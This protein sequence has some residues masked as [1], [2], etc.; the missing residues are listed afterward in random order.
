[1]CVENVLSTPNFKTTHIGL[2]GP[3]KKM[4]VE[5]NISGHSFSWEY[6]FDTTGRLTK[7]FYYVKRKLSSGYMYQY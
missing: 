3:V 5:S 6:C 7:Q 4:I 2:K 1:M